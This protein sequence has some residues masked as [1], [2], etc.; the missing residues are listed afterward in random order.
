MPGAPICGGRRR[1]CSHAFLLPSVTNV[2]FPQT[3]WPYGD[4]ADTKHIG[5]MRK[6]I[7]NTVLVLFAIVGLSALSSCGSS[8]DDNVIP[9]K[10]ITEFV[11]TYTVT[12]EDSWYQFFDVKATYTTETG[13]STVIAIT[14]NKKFSVEIPAD[15]TPAKCVF[16]VVATP[17]ANIG[18]VDESHSYPVGHYCAMNV[19]SCYDDNTT[20]IVYSNGPKIVHSIPGKS[21]KEWMSEKYEIY[22]SSCLID[23]D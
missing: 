2:I 8:S 16:K 13:D 21:V 7:I 9:T 20:G 17:K 23:K 1:R 12:L 3:V 22:S 10:K 4:Y 18:S 6:F 15:R 11:A 5:I 19:I 14:E